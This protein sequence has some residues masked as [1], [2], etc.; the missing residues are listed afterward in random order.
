M[1]SWHR[2]ER[3]HYSTWSFQYG[4][5]WGPEC[6]EIREEWMC[7]VPRVDNKMQTVR[8]HSMSKVTSD[9]P[10]YDV[11]KAVKELKDD[12]P[13]NQLLQNCKVPEIIS[14]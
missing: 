11:T 10:F 3:L 5:F 2:V 7:L 1:D 4:G 8:C 9:F 12:V 6:T 14:S 13:L